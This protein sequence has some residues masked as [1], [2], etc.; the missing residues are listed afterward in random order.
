MPDGNI[1]GRVAGDKRRTTGLALIPEM[2]AGSLPARAVEEL[3]NQH[4]RAGRCAHVLAEM[5]YADCVLGRDR[6][7]PLE[8]AGAWCGDWLLPTSPPWDAV[9]RCGT[10]VGWAFAAGA[11]VQPYGCSADAAVFELQ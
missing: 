5:P 7:S 10:R 11:G 3:L 8:M 9:G 1:P 6:G 2:R 4:D